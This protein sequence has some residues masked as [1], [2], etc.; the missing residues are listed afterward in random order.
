MR[1]VVAARGASGGRGSDGDVLD[2]AEAEGFEAGEWA[3]VVGEEPE[4]AEAQGAEDLAADAEVTEGGGDGVAIGVS[5]VGVVAAWVEVGPAD[6]PEALFEVGVSGVGGV[7]GDAFGTEV[8]EGAAAGGLDG[9]HGGV[10]GVGGGPFGGG[11][12]VGE[13]VA[14]EV[15]AVHSDEG[16][17]GMGDGVA[18]GVE[19][20]DAAEGEGDVGE[21]I[22]EGLEGE[23]VEGAEA[24]ADGGACGGR[25]STDEGLALEA[26]LDDLG[27]GAEFEVV[28]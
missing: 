17:L 11:V 12:E 16:G 24:G 19:V 10:E 2:D 13:D 5:E 27:D 18:G 9:A 3:G 28:E 25:E 7:E 15:S 26:V 6:E 4:V 14:E 1:G 21:W 23:E 22:D 8:D 20:A